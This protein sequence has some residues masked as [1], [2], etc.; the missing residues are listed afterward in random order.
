[1]RLIDLSHATFWMQPMDQIEYIP[2]LCLL[3]KYPCNLC[4]TWRAV[5]KMHPGRKH[6]VNLS[7]S[8]QSFLPAHD[9]AVP[10][11]SS[12]SCMHSLLPLSLRELY[13]SRPSR[14]IRLPSISVKYIHSLFFVFV[15]YFADYVF[16][17]GTLTQTTMYYFLTSMRHEKKK[18][19]A[20]RVA[21]ARQ[22]SVRS[23]SPSWS[24]N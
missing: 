10:D 16:S 13:A 19:R 4:R 3:A 24:V 15:F 11:T 18:K 9:F 8:D 12:A 17:R 2:N 20:A 21:K 6:A 14:Y 5:K 1:M 22:V 23:S 7:W